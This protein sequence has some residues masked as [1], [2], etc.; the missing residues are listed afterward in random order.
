[1]RTWLGIMSNITC[2]LGVYDWGATLEHFECVARE[3]SKGVISTI[4]RGRCCGSIIC[5]SMCE[6]MLCTVPVLSCRCKIARGFG[7]CGACCLLNKNICYFKRLCLG[8]GY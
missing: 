6:A 7:L 3:E 8:C 5:G 1:M 4:L 2:E